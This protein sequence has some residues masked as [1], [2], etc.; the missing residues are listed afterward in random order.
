MCDSIN[1][2]SRSQ[3]LR[4]INA[5]KCWIC[6]TILDLD[7]DELALIQQIFLTNPA[8][9]QI[10]N[11][12]LRVL[13][14]K[15]I[16]SICK[17]RKKI[18]HEMCFNNYIDSKQNGNVNVLV[19]CAQCNLAYQFIYPYN[20]LLL[21]IF[22]SIDQFLNISSSS[23]A[24]I[25]LAVTAYWCSLSFGVITILQIKGIEKGLLM[26]Q[27]SNI[28]MASIYLPLIP[29]AL[30]SG[31]FLQWE[32]ILQ[33]LMPNFFKCQIKN[34]DYKQNEADEDDYDE[35]DQDEKEDMKFLL[36]VRLVIGGLML[37]SIVLTIDRLLCSK[38][39]NLMRTILIGLGF[40]AFKGVSKFLYKQKKL[41]QKENREIMNYK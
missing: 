28:F 21:K 29:V 15:F 31:R 30:V 5:K 34:P 19:T 27:N 16:L 36:R 39:T 22:D 10:K 3:R 26:L 38:Q 23:F 32:K 11:I 12:Q 9:I 14:D 1:Q 6:L 20:G 41:W 37:P 4:F 35:E 18:A 2:T 33:N 40:V 25:S 24:L 17:C 8:Q 13:F 7:E